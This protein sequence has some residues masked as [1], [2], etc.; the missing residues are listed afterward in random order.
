MVE[1]GDAGSGV[2]AMGQNAPATLYR[3]PAPRP[4]APVP[5]LMRVV[6]RGEK[7]LLSLLPDI[8][9]ETMLS[10]LGYSRRGILLI[11]DPALVAEVMNDAQDQFPKNDLFVGALEGLVGNSMFVTSGDTWRRQRRMVDPAFSH[12][13]INRAFEF[14]Q[15]A[16]DD[17][18]ARLDALSASGE[19]FSLDAAMSHLTA[20]VITRTIF[21][22]PLA[23]QTSREVFEDFSAFERRVASI[24]VRRLLM[25]KAWAPIPQPD[26]VQRACQ[27]IRQHLGAMLDT[28]LAT[29][30]LDDIAGAVIEARDTDTGQG[31]T[32]EEIID[33]LGVFFLAGHETTASSLTW[34]FFI[35]SQRPDVVAR[36]R[37]EVDQVVGDGPVLL[38][39]TKKLTF[40]RNMFRE[41]LRLYPPITFIPRVALRDTTI[42]GRR[43]KRGTMLMIAPWAM[44]RHVKLW[45]HPD[46]FDPDRF[47]PE[48]EHE[49][50]PGAYIPFGLGPRI[51]VGAAFAT[52]ETALILARLVRRFDFESLSPETVR[53]FARLTTRP[54]VEIKARV[55]RNE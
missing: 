48:R 49:L 44:H 31:F 41:T 12:I 50:T 54:A 3:P 2:T 39:H 21:S 53:P 5:S 35:V 29:A 55:R 19:T 33:Q 18:E 47:L 23:S 43:V 8:A 40:V 1:H 51:C 16:V 46:R 4:R 11:N 27:R 14:M 28:R 42:G 32:R 30:G 25:D 22:T 26:D 17:Y 6:W 37:A 34:A 10:P 9:Y 38:E 52:I 15:G 24:D 45:K 13:R 20:D 36:M 7:D